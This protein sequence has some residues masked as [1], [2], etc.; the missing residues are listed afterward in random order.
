MISEGRVP[1][2]LDFW[3][4]TRETHPSEVLRNLFPDFDFGKSDGQFVQ[5][6]QQNLDV[7][8]LQVRVER[9]LARPVFMEQKFRRVFGRNVQVDEDDARRGGDLRPPGALARQG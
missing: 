5:P 6:R 8:V 3:F 7:S 1:R 9:G 4:R 2:V